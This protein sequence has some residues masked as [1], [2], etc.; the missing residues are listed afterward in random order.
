MNK[1]PTL[2]QGD[3]DKAGQVF[4][5]HRLQALVACFGHINGITAAACAPETGTFDAVTTTAI[6]AIQASRKLTVDGLVGPQTWSV[7]LTGSA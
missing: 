7:L 3:A 1:L 2:Q 6:K 4:F 5:V